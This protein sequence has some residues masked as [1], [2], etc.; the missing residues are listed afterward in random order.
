MIYILLPVCLGI[1]GYIIWY[2]VQ[3]TNRNQPIVQTTQSNIKKVNAPVVPDTFSLLLDYDDP[4]LG[5]R[6]TKRSATQRVS[7]SNRSIRKKNESIK[8][9]PPKPWPNIVY[10]G[11]VKNQHTGKWVALMEVNGQSHVL[12][13]GQA[14]EDLT[15][16]HLSEE[17]ISLTWKGEQGVVKEF[18]SQTSK[19]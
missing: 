11:L 7:S 3:A 18:E 8:E 4:F 5:K 6:T 14:V 9:E 13:S 10:K 17:K 12:R 2:V 1:W 16:I 19:N 15:L